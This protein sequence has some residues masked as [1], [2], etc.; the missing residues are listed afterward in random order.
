VLSFSE[1]IRLFNASR[2]RNRSQSHYYEFQQVQGE[3]LVRF[4]LENNIS[5]INKTLLDLGSG[6]GGYSSSFFKAK[7]NVIALDLNPINNPDQII[8]V[9]ADAN[10][11]PSLRES[12]VIV[13]V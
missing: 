10:N 13:Q 3:L 12:F 8:M 6:Y 11:I 2:L 5:L 9:K 4:I 1:A 7:A